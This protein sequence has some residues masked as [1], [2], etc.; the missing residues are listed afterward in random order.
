MLRH[1]YLNGVKVSGVDFSP[2]HLRVAREVMPEGRFAT[3]DI[4]SLP[5]GISEFDVVIAGSCFLYLPDAQDASK[6]LSELI[7][8][9]RSGG[10]GAVT[11]LP[12]INMRAESETFR[13]GELGQRNMTG[14]MPGW[15]IS[16]S[17]ATT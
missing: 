2:A 7:R 8:V 12:D 17:T 13:R 15:R 10:R 16:T 1:H 9:L 3:A 11:D 6:A 14:A 4:R 5:F